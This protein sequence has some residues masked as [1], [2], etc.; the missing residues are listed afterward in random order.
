MSYN[1]V[2]EKSQTQSSETNHVVN[3]QPEAL[4]SESMSAGLVS[5]H[6]STSNQQIFSVRP[7]P[8]RWADNICDWPKNLFPSCGCVCLCCYGMWIS[9]QSKI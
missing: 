8:G 2:A 9:A 4:H 1:P 7:P 3:V 6:I 5:N